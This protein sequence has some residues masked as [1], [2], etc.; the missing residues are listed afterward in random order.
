MSID[1]TLKILLPTLK[2]LE[3]KVEKIKGEGFEGE[4]CLKP[5]HIDYATV[6]IPGIFSYVSIS[7]KENYIALD[8][9]ILVKQGPKVIMV[10]RRAIAGEL[11]QLNNEVKNMLTERDEWEKQNRS[12]VA[13]LE[14][15]FIK[16]FLEFSHRN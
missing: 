4:F 13:M 8:Q 1:M 12:A 2:F 7:G 9:G 15:G 6:L 16:R 3:K 11:G 5:R 14:I 10:T